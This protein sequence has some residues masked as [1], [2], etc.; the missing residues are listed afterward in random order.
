[1]IGPTPKQPDTKVAVTIDL[2]ILFLFAP[3]VAGLLYT[4]FRISREERAKER[5]EAL[6]SAPP[7]GAT[8]ATP[9]T[10]PRATPS[11]TV[12]EIER[13]LRHEL[14][15]ARAFSANPSAQTLWLR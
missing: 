9:P 7:E 12:Y 2:I 1:V 15:L 8:L 11:S 4:G 6:L 13:R 10:E 14:T 3:V 5:Q